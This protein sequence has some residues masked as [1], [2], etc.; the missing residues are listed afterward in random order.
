MRRVLR[1]SPGFLQVCSCSVVSDTNHLLLGRLSSLSRFCL[2]PL[3]RASPVGHA[4][5]QPMP[6]LSLAHRHLQ[7][8]QHSP[9][10]CH[11]HCVMSAGDT[12]RGGTLVACGALGMAA[13][14]I[15]S[16]PYNGNVC[17][18]SDFHPY[19]Q[20]LVTP[21]GCSPSRVWTALFK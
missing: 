8:A 4:C 13:K 5:N 15:T 21:C 1:H 20:A 14:A 2:D 3:L 11:H 16:N 17:A 19:L 7:C 6:R 12:N 9:Y 18:H 10:H